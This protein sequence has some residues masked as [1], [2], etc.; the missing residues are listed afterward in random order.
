MHGERGRDLMQ[1]EDVGT[2][3]RARVVSDELPDGW[4]I[5]E[6]FPAGAGLPR[7]P[8]RKIQMCE[9]PMDGLLLVI[10]T[11]HNAED[12]QHLFAS[13]LVIVVAVDQIMCEADLHSPKGR[14]EH[15]VHV[16]NHYAFAF[17]FAFT[18]AFF[19][20]VGVGEAAAAT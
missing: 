4:I 7:L 9:S 3:P 1:P 17:T 16:V 15:E 18:L 12:S 6:P 19:F 5:L 14:M 10:S 13:A 2:V 11:F 8:G 20:F